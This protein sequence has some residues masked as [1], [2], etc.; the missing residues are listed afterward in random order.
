MYLARSA[1]EESLRA[2]LRAYFAIIMTPE[3]EA[4][5]G[6]GDMG[7]PHCP[8]AAMKMGRDGGLGICWPKEY[9]GQGPVGGT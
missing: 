9:G 6:N 8:E 5:V 1:A 4:E 7:G 2:E 3:V